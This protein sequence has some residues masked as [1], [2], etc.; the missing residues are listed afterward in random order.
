VCQVSLTYDL[1]SYA[2]LVNIESR[3]IIQRDS[4][5]LDE[6]LSCFSGRGGSASGTH[7][8]VRH[9]M[10]SSVFQREG[11]A[12]TYDAC[13]ISDR[14]PKQV[15]CQF[16]NLEPLLNAASIRSSGNS[17]EPDFQMIPLRRHGSHSGRVTGGKY[18]L[19]VK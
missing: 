6:L 9:P 4:C 18:R 7:G 14:R 1:G 19:A 12:L 3:T 11:D 17:W 15:R 8:M 5:S 2:R 10:Y 13:H 16:Y